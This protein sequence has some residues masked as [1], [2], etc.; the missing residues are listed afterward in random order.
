MG[1]ALK[2]SSGRFWFISAQRNTREQS[3]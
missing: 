3:D 2:N 1:N